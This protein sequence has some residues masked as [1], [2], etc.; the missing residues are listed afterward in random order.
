MAGVR[1]VIGGRMHAGC[2]VCLRCTQSHA[3]VLEAR[4]CALACRFDGCDGVAFACSC[5]GVTGMH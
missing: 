5:V 4:G 1:W 3:A 2:E